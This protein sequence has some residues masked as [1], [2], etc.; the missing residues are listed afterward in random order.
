MNQT[1]STVRSALIFSLLIGGVVALYLYSQRV[2]TL[3]PAGGTGTTFVPH[4]TVV[5]AEL[6]AAGMQGVAYVETADGGKTFIQAPEAT[7]CND[8]QVAQAN[9]I[10]AAHR[11]QSHRDSKCSTLYTYQGGTCTN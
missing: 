9:Q 11:V 6:R 1:G 3:A 4:D 10:C 2:E 7:G 8:L 5:T